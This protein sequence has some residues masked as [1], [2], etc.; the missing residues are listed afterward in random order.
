MSVR[1]VSEAAFEVDVLGRSAQVP[2]VVDFWA[3]WCAPC[4]ALGP[5]LEREVAALGGRVELAKVDVDQAQGLSAKFGVQ[6]I[7]AVMAFRDGKVVA[8]FV[9]ARDARFV[10]EWLAG[11]APSAA[12][13]RLEAATTADQLASL[14][15]DPEVGA[16]ASLK[17]AELFL[18]DGRVTEAMAQ[19]ATIGPRSPLYQRAEALKRQASFALEAAAFGGEPAARARLATNPDDIE[20]KFAL[21]N[22]L[23]ANGQ[24]EASLEAFLEVVTVDRKLRDDGARKAM[25]VLFERLG[26]AHALT[27]QFRRR[28]QV[29]L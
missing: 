2:V 13:Q 17:L 16:Q 18:A 3:A 1:D 27:Q 6:G 22:A 29:V 15:E 10:R 20:A 12:V 5:I 24:V 4:R 7:P 8:D 23:A 25:V 9:G 11:L 28:L 21:A 14:V 26:S 19:L